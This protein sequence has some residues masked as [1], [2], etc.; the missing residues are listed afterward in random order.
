MTDAREKVPITHILYQGDYRTERDAVEPGVPSI[1]DPNDMPI[2]KPI[3]SK[4]TGR[5]LTVAHWI[6][7]PEN[8][9]TARVLVNRLWQGYFGKGLVETSN[10]FGL[11]GSRPT[12]PELLDWLAHQCKNGSEQGEQWSMKRM[13]RLIVTSATYRQSSIITD[14]TRSYAKIDA[15]NTLYWRQNPRRLSAEQLRDAL[16]SVS[17]ILKNREG[18]P[19]I[20][21]TLPAEILQAN[22]AFLDDNSEKTKGW[23]E[24]P[25]ELQNVRSI[26]LVQKRTVRVPFL[27]TFDQPENTVSC[28]RRGSSTVAPQALSLLNGSLSL[29]AAR[30]LAQETTKTAGSEPL[31]KID[32]LYSYA[33]QR[34]PTP[35]ER[36]SCQE[37][38]QK[39]TL[40]ELARVLLNTNE[41]IYRD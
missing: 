31:Q 14:T 40:V 6:T 17:F 39:R 37:F 10:D 12:H 23:Y 34:A 15:E 4:T 27:E 32:Q 1:L 36:A 38:L 3:N 11:S 25:K 41:F 24:S 13:H 21:P 8:P 7:S 29:D 35:R 2:Q 18:G 20:W 22:P 33:F 28:A 16:L 19:P 26:Y 5:R 30:A 9:L